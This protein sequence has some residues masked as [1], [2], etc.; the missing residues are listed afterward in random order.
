MTDTLTRVG[1]YSSFAYAVAPRTFEWAG[2][3]Q[4]VVTI[5]KQ[6][7]TP[8]QIHFYVRGENDEFFELIYEEAGD[9]WTIRGFGITCPR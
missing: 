9:R 2:E 6:W 7:R 8:G 5:T 4:Q 3:T 1:A